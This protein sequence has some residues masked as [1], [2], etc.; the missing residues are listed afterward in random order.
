ML[1]C[2]VAK[3][4]FG[5]PGWSINWKGGFVSA[6]PDEATARRCAAAAAMEQALE[7]SLAYLE[8]YG[9]KGKIREIFTPLNHHQNDAEKPIRAALALARGEKE[10]G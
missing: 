10:A 8:K 2:E 9:P 7:S 6:M 4:R 5:V 3:D 1:T